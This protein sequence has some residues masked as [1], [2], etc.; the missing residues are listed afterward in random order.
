MKWKQK[1]GTFVCL[2]AI[3]CQSEKPVEGESLSNLPKMMK[4]QADAHCEGN[5]ST[6]EL[7]LS[8][9]AWVASAE[10][11][12]VG[13]VSGIGHVDSGPVLYYCWDENN[14]LSTTT[15][16]NTDACPLEDRISRA[17]QI[18]F[19]EVETIYGTP[20]GESVSVRMGPVIST[21]YPGIVYRKGDPY[22]T[23]AARNRIYRNGS[24]I[25]AALVTDAFGVKR[26]HYRQ[27]EVVNGKVYLSEVNTTADP[28]RIEAS[29]IGIPDQYDG[30]E[31]EDFKSAIL[32]S[33]TLTDGDLRALEIHNGLVMALSSGQ[34][35]LTKC[36]CE[37][38]PADWEDP[39]IPND[40]QVAP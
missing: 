18:D 26:W 24:R 17:I 33:H 20:L 4:A 2:A 23:D 27:F 35:T 36:G 21:D 38:R 32:G 15:L 39:A 30:V 7:E 12:F 8:F 3:G 9:A 6:G 34:F 16:P 11:I 40:P 13:T 19:E 28:C 25:G 14:D 22:P 10:S 37:D 1:L 29:E 5:P 31:F